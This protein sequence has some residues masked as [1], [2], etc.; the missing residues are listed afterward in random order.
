M[1]DITI[2]QVGLSSAAISAIV[3]GIVL[4]VF[5]LRV[6]RAEFVNDYHK[7][8]I[9]RRIAV[10]EQLEVLIFLIKSAVVDPRDNRSYHF[11]FAMDNPEE[12]IHTTLMQLRANSLWLSNKVF[13]TSRDFSILMFGLPSD[14]EQAVEFGKNHYEEISR[15]REAFENALAEDMRTLYKVKQFL[16]SKKRR[17]AGFSAVL[18]E[19]P[20]EP[21]PAG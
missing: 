1:A 20:P 3:S 2:W 13:E 17:H 7:L 15:I 6:K 5:N 21:S 16:R 4:G 9:Q 19:N 10:Y 12:V 8:I 18:L 11:V 14:K